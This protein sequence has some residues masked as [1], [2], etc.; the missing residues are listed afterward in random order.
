MR[1]LIGSVK[2]TIHTRVLPQFHH[3]ALPG[4]HE[5]SYLPSQFVTLCSLL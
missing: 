3:A 5:F 1:A 2:R 4:H